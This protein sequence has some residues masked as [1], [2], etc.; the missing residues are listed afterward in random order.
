MT[1][2][3]KDTIY[4]DVDDEIT[5]IIE[6]V[7][8]SSDKIVA[9]VLP[10]RAGVLQSIVNMKLLKRSADTQKKRIVLITSEAGLLPLAGAVGLHVAKTLQSKP[11]IP[12]VPDGPELEKE[13]PEEV[14]EPPLDP[15]KPVGELAGLAPTTDEETIEVD[16]D[17]VAAS[18]AAGAVAKSAKPPKGLRIP[19]FNKFRLRLIL[20]GLG[21]VLL[22]VGL[23]MA[24][25]VMPAAKIT[26]KTDTQT[27][28]AALKFTSSP[29]VK[30]FDEEKSIVPATIKEVKKTDSQKAQATGQKDLGEK[31][32]GKVTLALKDCSV[33][34]VTV[35]AGTGVSTDNLTYITTQPA[36]LNSVKIGGNCQNNSFPNISTKTVEVTAQNAGEQY[37]ISDGRTF[38]V[39]GYSSVTGS[40]GDDMSGGTSKVVKV[41]SQGDVDGLK[42][43]IIDGLTTNAKEELRQQF[44][45]EGLIPLEDTSQTGQPVVISSPNANEEAQEVSLSVTMTFNMQA[46]KEEHIAKLVEA[47]V[48]D[49]IDTSRQKISDNGLDNGAV[50]QINERRPNGDVTYGLQTLVTAGAQIDTEALKKEI[51]GKKGG[52]VKNLIQGRPGV[53]DVAVDFS[54]FWVNK[55]PKKPAKVTIIVENIDA[56]NQPR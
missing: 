48:K 3:G 6:K 54:P 33:D 43:K 49:K 40:N 11:A 27:V 56:N 17:D 10:K 34:A 19:D 25:F 45:S 30:E 38:S 51:A 46:V 20:G 26:I 22:I 7:R 23:Y 29:N 41:V 12:A 44:K 32:K 8:S 21:A 47:S 55:V 37:N 52:D 9:L 39:S 31:A 2:G 50:F 1:A 42:Q 16:N 4:I 35:P 5:S 14:A 24:N 53:K 13:A 28:N 15:E 36:T 18:A